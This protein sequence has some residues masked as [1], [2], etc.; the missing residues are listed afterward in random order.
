VIVEGEVPEL[1][2]P[3][4]VADDRTRIYV[5]GLE[6]F[7]HADLGRTIHANE[8]A[9]LGMLVQRTTDVAEAA[10]MDQ[11]SAILHEQTLAVK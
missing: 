10:V 5:D 11:H 2:K 3:A 6:Q 4:R 9:I 8:R 7:E 1:H